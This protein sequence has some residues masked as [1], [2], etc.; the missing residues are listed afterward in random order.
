[1]QRRVPG[2]PGIKTHYSLLPDDETPAAGQN[3]TYVGASKDGEGIA[4]AI[5]NK[6]YLRVGNETT[7]EVGENV[8]FA[9]VSEGG[10][11]VFY[12][13]GGDLKALDT[14]TT[15]VIR[16]PRPGRSRRVRGAGASGPPGRTPRGRRGSPSARGG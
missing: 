5:A 13:E 1:M 10:E 12:V 9:G 8:T 4:F 14:T 2:H 6:L 3:A 11:R 15:P 7:Y 16:R